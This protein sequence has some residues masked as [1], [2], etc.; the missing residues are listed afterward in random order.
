MS[1]ENQGV[2]AVNA[3]MTYGKN[4]EKARRKAGLSQTALS[5][6]LGKTPATISNWESDKFEP[7]SASD[8]VKISEITGASLDEL[9]LGVD[10]RD[11]R[12]PFELQPF[13]QSIINLVRVL[14]LD[15]NDV[16]LAITQLAAKHSPQG[17][18]AA[19]HDADRGPRP[20]EPSRRKK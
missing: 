7:S 5:V 16:I 4:I 8:W 9:I 3:G 12:E 6:S 13:E 17:E 18:M 2:K 20:G 10:P 1:V 15:P 14:R 19:V 11:R